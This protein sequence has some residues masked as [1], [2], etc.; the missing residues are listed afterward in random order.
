MRE[1]AA[2]Y[3]LGHTVLVI[4]QDLEYHHHYYQQCNEDFCQGP[5][6]GKVLESTIDLIPFVRVF[7]FIPYLS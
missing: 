6:G 5:G 7:F 3:S 2:E 4:E 1:P